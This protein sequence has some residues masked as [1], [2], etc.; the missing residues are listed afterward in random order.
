VSRG[1][2]IDWNGIAFP[3]RVYILVSDV[4]V[5][6][7]VIVLRFVECDTSRIVRHDVSQSRGDGSDQVLE[8]EVTNYGIINVEQ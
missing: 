7:Q 2:A 8:I 5:F 4:R 6:A 3:K 1:S